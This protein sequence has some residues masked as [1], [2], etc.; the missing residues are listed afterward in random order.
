M[1]TSIAINSINH[2]LQRHGWAKKRL[3]LLAGKVAHVEIDPVLAF[4]FVVDDQGAVQHADEQ[5]STD[6]RITVDLS[7]LPKILCSDENLYRYLKVSGN[8]DFATEL[9]KIVQNIDFDVAQ[10]LSHFIGDIPAHRMAQASTKILNWH[11]RGI[12]NISQA[13]NEYLTEE[14]PTLA[15]SEHAQQFTRDVQILTTQTE[16]LE[17]KLNQMT[18]KVLF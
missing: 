15:K 3:Q 4:S 18:H 7:T 1:L 6:T 8:H 14:C 12:Q 5:S 13:V 2:V 17:Q 11:L 16:Q 10:D 9:V